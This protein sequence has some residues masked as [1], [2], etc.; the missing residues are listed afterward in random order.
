LTSILS[1][2][3]LLQIYSEKEH[4]FKV[5]I[6]KHAMKIENSVRILNN[7][8]TSV[9]F[10]GKADADQMKFR[11]KKMFT[12][13]FVK[14]L[15]DTIKAGMETDV[16]INSKTINLPKTITTDS[17]LLYQVL[18]NLLSNA[19]KYSGDG[20]EVDFTLEY[21]DKNLVGTIVDKGI[22]IPKKEQ[23]L[24][25]DRFFRANNVGIIEGSGLGLSIAKKCVEVLKGEIT[26][27]SA[28]GKGT[29]FKIVIP[30]T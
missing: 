3:Q 23:R 9:L 6:A 2:A 18:D 17:E 4:P 27:E 5:K 15:L 16:K 12:G 24:L 26:F 20:Q 1:S 21:I 22:G 28:E 8:L 14:E 19:T 30:V 13:A 7:L 29:T 10:F 11:P 25:F